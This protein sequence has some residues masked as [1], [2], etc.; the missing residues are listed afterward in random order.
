MSGSR[1]S[2]WVSR[3][4]IAFPLAIMASR[5]RWV[6]APITWVSSVF[7]TIPALAA[8]ALLIPITGLSLTT[9]AIPLITYNLLILF[10]NSL[11]RTGCG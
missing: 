2:P 4:V 11:A 5:R 7:Y 8:I 6:I 10:R 1:W 3:L 9:V